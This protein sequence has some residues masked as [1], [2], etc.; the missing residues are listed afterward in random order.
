[1][2][3]DLPL[4]FL[5]I[6]RLTDIP[7]RG[8]RCVNA[9]FGRIAVFRTADDRVFATEDR[10]PHKGGPLSQGI[11]HDGRVTCPLHSQVIALDTGLVQ[12]PDEG[13]VRTFP[14]RLAADGETIELGLDPTDLAAPLV[15]AAE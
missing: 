15:Q 11:V 6:G 13:H 5:P 7:R 2:P 4:R 12:G 3:H 8:A 14:V 10:C 1:M 9:P